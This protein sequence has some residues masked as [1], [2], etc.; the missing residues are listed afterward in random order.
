MK[1]SP[2]VLIILAL[3]SPFVSTA[4]AQSSR[5]MKTFLPNQ[6]L[7]G[8]YAG[9]SVL[10]NATSEAIP[11][12]NISIHLSVKGTAEDV[13]VT[14]F[15]LDIYAF[16]EGQ[17]KFLLDSVNILENEILSFNQIIQFNYTLYVPSDV[18]GVTYTTMYLEYTVVDTP[19]ERRLSFLTTM[20]KNIYLEE[21]ENEFKTLNIT[22]NQLKEKFRNLNTTYH[23]LN[24]TF[25]KSFQKPLTNQSLVTLNHTHKELKQNYTSIKGRL[26]HLGN[27][28]LAI[29]I[30]A[31]TTVFFLGTTIYVI[32]RKRRHYW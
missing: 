4:L 21:L 8:N 14:N 5:D 20:I 28:R 15:N 24:G 18:W 30:L 32:T 10:F 27:T 11:G 7:T 13:N 9:L 16:K 6:D 26:N 3:S 17:E 23:Q 31:V 1:V 22:H 12:E 19:V 29:T 2:L 25:W